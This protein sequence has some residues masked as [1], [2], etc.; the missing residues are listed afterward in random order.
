MDHAIS[1]PSF[2]KAVRQLVTELAHND[3]PVWSFSSR[4]HLQYEMCASWSETGVLVRI[5]AIS[6]YEVS[7][8]LWEQILD[9]GTESGLDK[10]YGAVYHIQTCVTCDLHHGPE[11]ECCR[12]R[13]ALEHENLCLKKEIA[14]LRNGH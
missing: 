12:K 5:F 13:V 1:K 14:S 4:D 7:G 8:P 3:C 2:V 10:L 11:T 6:G 9:L